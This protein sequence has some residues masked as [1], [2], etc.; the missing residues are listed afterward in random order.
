[1]VAKKSIGKLNAYFE[2]LKADKADE[3]KPSH[4][5]KIIEKLKAKKQSLEKDIEDSHKDSKKERLKGNIAVVQ[6][7]IKRAEWL[8]K[9]ID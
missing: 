4:V 3:I 7:Q 2:R 5:D 6:E 8:K 1:M 9:R